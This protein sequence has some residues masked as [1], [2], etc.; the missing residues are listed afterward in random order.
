MPAI[1]GRA[2]PC[3]WFSWCLLGSPQDINP[4]LVE[5]LGENPRGNRGVATIRRPGNG[6]A[7]KVT[8]YLNKD[9]F[10]AYHEASHV[11]DWANH[12][13]D[14]EN[15]RA[16]IR[17]RYGSGV[18]EA[19]R[20]Y[21]AEIL[22]ARDIR[23]ASALLEDTGLTPEQ[24]KIIADRLTVLRKTR[25]WKPDITRIPKSPEDPVIIDDTNGRYVVRYPDGSTKTMGLDKAIEIAKENGQIGVDDNLALDEAVAEVGN[26]AL[27]TASLQ[28]VPDNLRQTAARYASRFLE[29]LGLV[30]VNATGQATPVEGSLGLPPSTGAEMNWFSQFRATAGPQN[31]RGTSIAPPGPEFFGNEG[32]GG[33]AKQRVAGGLTPREEAL[34]PADRPRATSP[35][36]TPPP[37]ERSTTPET[38]V[39]PVRAGIIKVD[40]DKV[41]VED[42]PGIT[43]AEIN[44]IVRGMRDQNIPEDSVQRAEA[45][46]RAK[47]NPVVLTYASATPEGRLPAELRAPRREQQKETYLKE[48]GAVNEQL[49]AMAEETRTKFTRQFLPNRIIVRHGKEG[50]PQVNLQGLSPSK[51]LH[52]VVIL[53]G[54]IRDVNSALPPE[55]RMA[56]PYQT[57]GE[58]GQ[59]RFNYE[60]LWDGLEKYTENQANGYT[61]VGERLTRPEG[62]LEITP[63]ENPNFTPHQLSPVEAAFF[64]TLMGIEPP[65]S[66]KS[67]KRIGEVTPQ[68]VRSI[69]KGEKPTPGLETVEIQPVHVSAFQLSEAN[70]PGRG[71]PSIT[72]ASGVTGPRAA[73]AKPWEVAVP[74]RAMRKGVPAT[75]VKKGTF[76]DPVSG[77]EFDIQEFNLLRGEVTQKARDTIDKNF[78][79]G[80]KL[81]EAFEELNAELISDV[82]PVEPGEGPKLKYP[83]QTMIEAGFMPEGSREL[84]DK[85]IPALRLDTGE[86]ILGNKREIHDEIY[87]ALDAEEMGKGTML[88]F[89]SPEHGFVSSDAPD[90]FI[91][92][93][94]AAKDLGIPGELHSQ[95]L[96]RLREAAHKEV[97][98]RAMPETDTQLV[99]ET[100]KRLR[101]NEPIE[102]GLYRR[103]EAKPY[104]ATSEAGKVLEQNGIILKRWESDGGLGIVAA[105]GPKNSRAGDVMYRVSEG[106][107]G[108][109][110]AHI[111]LIDVV[112]QF[113]GTRN[114]SVGRMH[115]A[116]ALYRELAN[117]VSAEG[118]TSIS[119]EPISE[120]AMALRMRVFDKTEV[121][122]LVDALPQVSAERLKGDVEEAGGLIPFMHKQ[123]L[124]EL[125]SHFAHDTKFMPDKPQAPEVPILAAV[126]DTKTGDVYTGPMHLFAY[127]KISDKGA[128]TKFPAEMSPDG[129]TT[130]FIEGFATNKRPFVDREEAGKLAREGLDPEIRGDLKSEQIPD[131]KQALETTKQQG[132]FGGK[133]EEAEKALEENMAGIKGQKR[134][135]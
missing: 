90:Q 9:A 65:T 127:L 52:N 19:W 62:F 5:S 3:T 56:L 83:S 123:G 15:N 128:M 117:T 99:E 32:P 22:A 10:S 96:N 30:K 43:D 25:N 97:E 34:P 111:Q 130:R 63:P 125:V 124:F 73:E 40:P 91:T 26:S 78:D 74:T 37:A 51:I 118:V 8:M 82:R 103:K 134:T 76:R 64:N 88:R 126:K 71:Q 108:R 17:T 28:G 1:R 59:L 87:K 11:L 23:K 119:G 69:P 12:P 116:E 44:S 57:P 4:E 41:S 50:Q 106:P 102:P 77:R 95:E 104:E 2:L 80:D 101:E 60:A 79:L 6:G 115:V 122:N 46:L 107:D 84:L 131:I 120:K 21:Y 18:L 61:G 55:K 20:R 93:K 42:A 47:G 112:Q 89:D 33:T 110:D 49:Q 54:I 135:G 133:R 31:G 129:K 81:S 58:R 13:A 85:L 35:A 121:V 7:G 86:L 24:R 67:M 100:R 132:R 113:R 98:S 39:A 38:P 75:V 48:E 14:R 94:Q 27:R 114:T 105:E 72:R 16:D 68:G 36:P 45:V 109:L 70:A 92:R 29:E 66:T 53:D